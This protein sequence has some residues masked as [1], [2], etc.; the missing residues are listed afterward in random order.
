MRKPSL[1]L[2]CCLV[3]SVFCLFY[4]E[5][6]KA[7]NKKPDKGP[8]PERLTLSSQQTSQ[9]KQVPEMIQNSKSAGTGFA[10][11]ELFQ[12][13]ASAISLDARLGE[14]LNDGAVFDLNVSASESLLQEKAEALTLPLPDGKGGMVELELIKVDIFA[15]GFSVKTSMPTNEPL[16]ESL[17]VHYRG[18][19]KGNDRSLAAISIFKDEVMGFY[20]T[21]ANGN[22]IL[23]RLG[24]DNLT[25]KHVLYAERDLKVS[26][27]FSCSTEYTGVTLPESVLQD[28]AAV[29]GACVKIY[30]EADYDVYQ[31]KGSVANVTSYLTGM[32]NQSA[33][34]F[35]ND[36]IPVSISEIY[37]WNSPSPYTGNDSATALNQF[38]ANRTSFNGDLA[39]LV[40]TGRGFGGRAWIDSL[41]GRNSPYAVSD[42]DSTYQSVPTYSWTVYVFTHETGHNLGSPHTQACAWNGD[43]TAIDGCAP[44]EG[45]SC[46]QPGI[47]S[48]G[49]TL[50]SYCHLTSVGI[51]FT[52]GFGPQP[53]NLIVNR[54]NASGCL[55]AC[56]GGC[57][58]TLSPTSRSFTVSG[59]SSSF[60]VTTGSSCSWTATVNAPATPASLPSSQQGDLLSAGSYPASGSGTTGTAATTQAVWRNSTS[61][62]VN[63]RPSS[64][65]PPG[66]GS[67][68]SSNIGVSG[69]TGTITKV[70]VALNNLSHT[71]PDDVDVLLVGPGGQRA[72][73]MSDAGGSSDLSGVNLI[74][75]QSAAAMP[76][77]AQ[78]VSGT[79]R[80]T[81]FNTN[82]TLE[83]GGVDNFPSPGP[84][85]TVYG[86]DLNVFNGTAPNGTWRLYVVDDEAGDAGSIAT[87]WALVITTNGGGT[88]WINI[89][90]SSIGMG[91]GTVSYT[92][93]ANPGASQRTGTITV[94]GQVH[95]ITQAGSGGGCSS[96][97]IAPGQTINGSLT[98]SDCVL[99][100]TTRYVDVYSFNGTAGQKVAV[101][102]SSSAFDT[103]LYLVNSSSQILVGND[104]GGGGTNSR[105]PA[106]SGFFTLPATGSYSIRATTYYPSSTGSYSISLVNE[107]V[108][109]FSISP[110]SRSFSS[111]GGNGSFSVSSA[112]GC[113]W[114]AVSNAGWITT[115]SSGTGNGTVNYTVAANSGTSQRTGTITVNGRT[116]TVT[117]SFAALPSLTINNGVVTEGNTG[118][119]SASFTVKLS[120]ATS[121]E[122]RVS[123]KTANGTAVAGSDY[124]TTQGQ[125]VFS[126]G[127]TTKSV[128]VPV[129]GDLLAEA[130]ETFLVNLSAP[131]NA[132]IADAQA[133][134]TITD[135]EVSTKI[136]VN[137]VTVT[138]RNTGVNVSA[139]FTVSLTAASTQTV[140]VKYATANGTALATADYGARSLTTLTFLP[141]QTTRTVAV[142]VRGD[143]LD[144]V[145]ETFKLVLS[146][147]AN[148]TLYNTQGVC[149]I[150][151]DDPPPSITIS[152]VSVTEPDSG[153]INAAFTV[154]LSSPSG[155][156]VSVKYQTAPGT[157]ASGVDYTARALTT[158]TFSPGQTTKTITVP[159]RGDT[160]AEPNETFFV[161]LSAPVNATIADAQGLGT[162]LNDD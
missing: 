20:S 73:L 11:R 162:I 87:G 138:E 92:V 136:R 51:N 102:M 75:N 140:T 122:V 27:E 17:G 55:T 111:P 71:F 89:T 112:S 78:L 150:I 94:N 115:S 65:N 156:P 152:N 108:C 53:H 23:G 48:G 63:D 134:G 154:M 49:G 42:I 83:P 107:T 93:A 36:D 146:S 10:R 79:Y 96:T 33:T 100:G 117:Q 19:V 84:G 47:P 57:T 67:P 12:S 161:N 160:T 5:P 72:I 121:S 31:N 90:S 145:N 113:A 7:Q 139:V 4:F 155:R 158:L 74:F 114:S 54:F 153:T 34:L 6:S 144:E 66:T 118:T 77:A 159:V 128:I 120:A 124:Q 30:I 3:F 97:T 29:A 126:P 58:Y 142:Q 80:P 38:R 50:M 61:I 125:L 39:H 99:S 43:G 109:T 141:G 24:G 68:Y 22:F 35:A 15:P 135:N 16:D 143:V 104:D 8:V 69:M 86:A 46:P 32:F 149:T 13:A 105:I 60:S 1:V 56:G 40:T 59:G 110:T 62:T 52:F 130:N 37:V 76:D 2:L 45:G 14:L 91:N 70:E 127:Q 132:S 64:S 95:T 26:S 82:T 21:E 28:T 151:D 81:N 157:A 9:I 88:S 25:N 18:I 123:Y 101:S 85:Q 137:S 119:T 129:I 106:T 131:I 147:P 98:T 116:H 41:C 44:V 148:A 133:V 103:Y